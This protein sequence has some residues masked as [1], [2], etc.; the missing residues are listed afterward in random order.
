MS[1]RKIPQVCSLALLLAFAILP[2]L[3]RSEDITRCLEGLDASNSAHY[4]KAI[5]S[6]KACIETGELGQEALVSTY[7]NLGIAY[8]MSGQPAKAKASADSAIAL[9]PQ[10][11]DSDYVNRGNA[12]D[13]E[14]E[15]EQ[16]FEDYNHALALNPKSVQALYNRGI[17]YEHKKDFRRAQADFVAAFNGGLRSALLHERLVMYRVIKPGNPD[18]WIALTPSEREAGSR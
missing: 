12:L 1:T 3:G 10:D 5:G 17:A 11:V 2:A 15:S 14:G 18:E 7:R 6:F 8:R 16:A 4:E 13:D 9:Q